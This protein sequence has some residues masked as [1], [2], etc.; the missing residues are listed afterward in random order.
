MTTKS[1]KN[2]KKS[3][4]HHKNHSDFNVTVSVPF[5]QHIS[6]ILGF[7]QLIWKLRLYQTVNPTLKLLYR[8]GILDNPKA[9][10]IVLII[11]NLFKDRSHQWLTC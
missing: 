5:N 11:S 1:K 7:P 2:P 8:M 10:T 9:V 3:N 4:H 6:S